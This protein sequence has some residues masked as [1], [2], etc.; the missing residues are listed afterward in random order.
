MTALFRD[1]YFDTIELL[2]DKQRHAI[3]NNNR[4]YIV[5]DVQ[6]TNNGA[7]IDLTLTNDFPKEAFKSGECSIFDNETF[8]E[9]VDNYEQTGKKFYRR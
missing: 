3:K 1:H 4:D 9:L 2:T 6:A 5:I 7:W 8:E